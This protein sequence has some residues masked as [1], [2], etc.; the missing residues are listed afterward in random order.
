[1]ELPDGLAV[2]YGAN[3]AGKSPALR[4]IRSLFYGIEERAAD[5]QKRLCPG[6]EPGALGGAPRCPHLVEA[7]DPIPGAGVPGRRGGQAQ[8]PDRACRARGAGERP[9]R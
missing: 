9:V 8:G 4:A 1:M 2:L 7:A 6:L 5:A 3:E